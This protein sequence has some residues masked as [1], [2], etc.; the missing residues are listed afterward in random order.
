MVTLIESFFADNVYQVRPYVDDKYSHDKCRIFRAYDT[1]IILFNCE[2]PVCDIYSSENIFCL[3]NRDIF[4]Y[5]YLKNIT[6]FRS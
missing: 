6:S 2:L 1:T 4:I 3:M 5:C